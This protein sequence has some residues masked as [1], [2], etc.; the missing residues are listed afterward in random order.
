M[1]GKIKWSEEKIAQLQREGRGSGTGASYKPWIRVSDFSSMGKSRRMFSA[2]CGRVHELLSDGERNLFLLLEFSRSVADIREQF[3]LNRDETLSLA[4]ELGIKHP[5]YPTT[6]VP[7]VMTTDFLV[8]F[9]RDGKEWLEA[10]SCKTATDIEKPR[11]M[12]KLEIERRYFD[13]LEI[14][15]RLV[16]DHTL[17]VNK[18]RN[19]YWLR[20]AVLDDDGQADY[21]GEYVELGQRLLNELARGHHK[22]SLAE[23]CANFDARVGAQQGTGLFVARALLW[24]GALLT[25]LNQPNLP[26][27]PIA[28]FSVPAV[29]E[30]RV[31]GG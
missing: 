11:T 6:Q 24:N 21:P 2:K 18:V 16:L 19:V 8:K 9:S 1:A 23:Y 22:G 30:L 25:D 15:F 17:P 4:A 26:A 28:M 31:V 10:F 12:E 27:A 7:T 13:D 20:G 5:V 29:A 14:P 3:P